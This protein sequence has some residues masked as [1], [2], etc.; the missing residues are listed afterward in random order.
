MLLIRQMTK[1]DI[2]QMVSIQ[3][4]GWQTAYRGII[5]D[6][7][8]DAMSQEEHIVKQKKDLLNS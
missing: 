6:S 2:P 3:I 8:L 5:D 4:T 7:Y 1:E